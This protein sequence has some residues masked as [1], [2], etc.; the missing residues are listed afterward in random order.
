MATSHLTRSKTGVYGYR[1]AVPEALRQPIGRLEIKKTLGSDY[2]TAM[3]LYGE[4]HAA[5]EKLFANAKNAAPPTDQELVLRTLKNAGA[6]PKQLEAIVAGL[7]WDGDADGIWY[8]LVNE[9]EA[10]EERGETPKVS[11]EAIRAIGAQKLPAET[12][13]LATA[14]SFY[15]DH[16]KSGDKAKDRQLENNVENLKA[17]MVEALGKDAV[18]KR[19]LEAL[20]RSDANKIRDLLLAKVQPNTVRRMFNTLRAAVN[21]TIR[22]YD[23]EMRNP[24]EKVEIKGA[25]KG[26]KEDRAP[27]SEA[28]MKALASVMVKGPDDV[29]GILWTVLRDTGARVSEVTRRKVSDVDFTNASITIPFGKT[30]NSIRTVPLSPSALEGLQYRAKDKAPDAFLFPAYAE[31]R[32]NDSASQAL[33]KRLRTVVKDKKKVVH[34]LRHRL[35]DRLRAVDCPK[36]IR[37]EITGHN[38][39]SIAENY[40]EGH[41]LEKKRSY[42]E[43]VW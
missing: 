30:E 7:G 12:Y 23:L 32:G 42:L 35:K 18:N 24:V 33:M 38:A 9:Y 10:A 2:T 5:T 27:L 8:G 3:K 39:Q 4:V 14:L 37:D 31:G 36:D 25:R 41:S 11:L 19:P 1:R 40:G 21:M 13:T 17:R 20:K 6:T 29:L 15:L 43:R 16:K 22:E 28:D 26:A 34:S